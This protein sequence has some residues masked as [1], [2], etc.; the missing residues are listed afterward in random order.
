[1]A[2]GDFITQVGAK[3]LTPTNGV[4]NEVPLVMPTAT[5]LGVAGAPCN[6]LANQAYQFQARIPLNGTPLST[7]LTCVLAVVDDPRNPGAGLVGKF[8]ITIK[9]LNGGADYTQTSAS[10]EVTGTVTMNA[11]SGIESVVSLAVTKAAISASLAAGDSVLVQLRRLGTDAADTH[12]GVIL[13][14]GAVL[15]DT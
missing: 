13:I 10:T 3:D 14:T 6:K 12:Q 2:T 4:F 1:M 15:Q 11:T 5:G 8:G 7:G 9:R